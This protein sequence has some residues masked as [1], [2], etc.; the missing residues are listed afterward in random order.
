MT[1]YT[2]NMEIHMKE[3][4]SEADLIRI[5]GTESKTIQKRILKECGI[6]FIQKHDKTICT[7]WP[8]VNHALIQG[9]ENDG[10]NFDAMDETA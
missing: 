2:Q 1:Q 9:A 3:D 6:G 7:T 10:I 4:L 8:A 5:T